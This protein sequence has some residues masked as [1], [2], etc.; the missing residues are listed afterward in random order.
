MSYGL[1]GRKLGHSYSPEIHSHFGSC[2]YALYEKEPE[3]LKDFLKNGDFKGINVTIPY[4]KDVIPY[5]D[6]LSDKAKKLQS[7]NTV[8][9]KPDGTL[10]GH[11]TD[12]FGF[13]YL[14]KRMT[15]TVTGQKILVLGSGGASNTV[16]S[17]L[18]DEGANVVIISR[19]GEN[20]YGNL[21]MHR[22]ADAIVNTTPVGMFPNTGVSPIDLTLFPKLSWVLDIIYNPAKTQLL[23]DAEKL[24]IPHHIFAFQPEFEEHVIRQFVTAYETGL[25]PNPCIQCNVHLKFGAMLEKALDMGFDYVVSG[26]Y[27]Q[28][29]RD[30]ETGRYLLY[31]AKDRSKAAV[32]L[33]F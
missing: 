5:L 13:H 28:T 16:V 17:V 31:K 7:V 27:A 26:H 8:I 32:F 10:C 9:R 4:K 12:H 30:S 11:N 24:G 1:L 25:T 15:D 29:R 6:T 18:Q 21:H 14:L 19:S 23:L 20:N 3:Q 22:D 2:P 33:T